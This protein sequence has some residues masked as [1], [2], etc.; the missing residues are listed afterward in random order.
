MLAHQILSLLPLDTLRPP[1]SGMSVG[2]VVR[3]PA[4]A[5][6]PAQDAMRP[7]KAIVLPIH[8]GN[9]LLKPSIIMISS[10]VNAFSGLDCKGELDPFEP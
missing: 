3:P 5:L 8:R 7:R 2:T 6:W 10:M 1:K 4:A 9:R